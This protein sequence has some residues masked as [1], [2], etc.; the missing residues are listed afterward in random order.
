MTVK[1]GGE[2]IPQSPVQVQAFTTG[3]VCTFIKQLLFGIFRRLL[4]ITVTIYYIL[5]PFQ[6]E[7]RCIV[8]VVNLNRVKQVKIQI[9]CYNAGVRET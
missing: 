1:Y 2:E 8:A 5:A 7:N 6:M 4:V 3:S 9:V